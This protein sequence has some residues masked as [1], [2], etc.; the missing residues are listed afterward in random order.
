MEQQA[1]SSLTA[2]PYSQYSAASGVSSVESVATIMDEK[3]NSP[4]NK[5]TESVC[6]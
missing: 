1:Q 5:A 6:N 4:L 3:Q 2:R